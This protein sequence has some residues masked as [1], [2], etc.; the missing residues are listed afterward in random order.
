MAQLL[1]RNVGD[2]LVRKLK[3]RA[4]ARGVSA[5]EEHRRILAESLARDDRKRPALVSFLLSPQGTVAPEVE[6]DLSRRRHPE[7]RDTGF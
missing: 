2:T 3:R 7:T 4:K 6:L 5:E 1:V